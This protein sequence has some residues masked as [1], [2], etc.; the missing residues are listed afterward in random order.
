MYGK[1]IRKKA[2][3]KGKNNKSK[4]NYLQKNW[5]YAKILLDILN[6]WKWA[7]IWIV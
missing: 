5:N 1:K 4:W 3:T 6:K 2:L 7:Y